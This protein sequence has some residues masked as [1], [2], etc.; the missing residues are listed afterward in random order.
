VE[1]PFKVTILEP[2]KFVF[3]F[4]KAPEEGQPE[5]EGTEESGEGVV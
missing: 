3:N 1:A 4:D 5:E 2:P